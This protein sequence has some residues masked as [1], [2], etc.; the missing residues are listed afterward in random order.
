MIVRTPHWVPCSAGYVIV[1]LFPLI[2]QR[3]WSLSSGA[4][5]AGSEKRCD[6]GYTSKPEPQRESLG[7]APTQECRSFG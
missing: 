6:D 4:I 3:R 5:L 7:V 1:S 2:L